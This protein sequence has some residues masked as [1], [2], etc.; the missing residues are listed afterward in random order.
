MGEYRKLWWT[1]ITILL[2]T[3]AILGFS[4]KEIYKHAP[5]IPEQVVSASQQV[6]MT[7]QDILDGQT[8]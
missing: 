5:P 6:L 3:F 2:V 4:G 7:K 1:L 8:A